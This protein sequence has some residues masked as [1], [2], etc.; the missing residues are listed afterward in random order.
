MSDKWAVY[1]EDKKGDTSFVRAGE[2]VEML[3]LVEQLKRDPDVVDAWVTD[4]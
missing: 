3:E 2:E 1:K 4:E